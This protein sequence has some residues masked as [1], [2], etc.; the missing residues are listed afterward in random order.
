MFRSNKIHVKPIFSRIKTKF[1]SNMP[2]PND[3]RLQM[4]SLFTSLDKEVVAQ[5]ERIFHFPNSITLNMQI[6]YCVYNKYFCTR[7]RPF[8]FNFCWTKLKNSMRANTSNA[9]SLRYI[10]LDSSR[11]FD[12]WL[13]YNYITWNSFKISNKNDERLSFTFRNSHRFSSFENLWHFYC[14]YAKYENAHYRHFKHTFL[15][16][17]CMCGVRCAMCIF[18]TK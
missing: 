14:K 6:L 18:V 16:G 9:Y 3:K 15:S 8:M 13:A 2:Q 12:L 5:I 10:T 7:F 11:I 4:C 1:P 17:E